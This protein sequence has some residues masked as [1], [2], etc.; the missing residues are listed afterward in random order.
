MPTFFIQVLVGITF[1]NNYYEKNL[2]LN[3]NLIWIISWIYDG[4][5]KNYIFQIKS[6]K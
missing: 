3:F 2:T 5:I 4:K 6:V 1:L